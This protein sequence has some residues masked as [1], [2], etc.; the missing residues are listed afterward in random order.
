MVPG[1][2]EGLLVDVLMKA[3]VERPLVVRL[4]PAGPEAT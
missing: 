4:F 3:S 2:N 1:P